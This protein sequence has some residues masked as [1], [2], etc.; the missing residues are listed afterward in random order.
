MMWRQNFVY[1]LGDVVAL[2]VNNTVLRRLKIPGCRC[3]QR[4]E[5]LNRYVPLSN[6]TNVPR[7]VNPDEKRPCA[8]KDKS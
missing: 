6:S 3:A 1:G 2:L 4:Q 7:Q 5:W 8:C